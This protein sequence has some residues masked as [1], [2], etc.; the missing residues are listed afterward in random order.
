MEV[1]TKQRDWLAD[2][3]TGKAKEEVFKREFLGYLN[4]GYIDVTGDKDFQ[5]RDI[6]VVANELKNIDVKSFHADKTP[7]TIP[8]EEV[9]VADGQNGTII[10]R[11]WVHESGADFFAFVCTVTRTMII[12]KND[13]NFHDLWDSINGEF[14]ERWQTTNRNGKTW[15]SMHKNVPVNKLSVAWYRKNSL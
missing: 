1:E 4:I 15:W 7:L 8:I 11:G 9:S 13:I 6:D 5:A 3:A 2:I 10:R 14:E 12:L